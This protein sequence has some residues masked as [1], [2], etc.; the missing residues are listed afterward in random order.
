MYTHDEDLEIR[1]A[2][3]NWLRKVRYMQEMKSKMWL[4]F[5]FGILVGLS[6]S[7]I[8]FEIAERYSR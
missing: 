8:L 3:Q 1:K 7:F 2:K 6:V 5:L 4:C